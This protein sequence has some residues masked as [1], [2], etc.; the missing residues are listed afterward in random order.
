MAKVLQ[1]ALDLGNDPVL[2]KTGI[3]KRTIGAAN[4]M[5]GLGIDLREVIPFLKS[6]AITN[7]VK[8]LEENKSIFTMFEDA[9]YDEILENEMDKLVGAT[10]TN[11]KDFTEVTKKNE[12]VG[13]DRAL[14]NVGELY[15]TKDRDYV[16][17]IVERDGKLIADAGGVALSQEVSDIKKFLRFHA[18]SND[19]IKVSQVMQLDGGLPKSYDELQT[20]NKAISDMYA[21]EDSPKSMMNYKALMDRPLFKHY[22]ETVE[23][24]NEIHRTNFVTSQGYNMID[25]FIRDTGKT[26]KRNQLVNSVMNTIAQEG[27]TGVDDAKPFID[28]FHQ[29][30]QDIK[31]VLTGE[32][33]STDP[34]IIKMISLQD[35]PEKLK[36]YIE[37]AQEVDG[38]NPMLEKWVKFKQRENNALEAVG[39]E[40][41]L[42]IK[43]L[44]YAIYKTTGQGYI[45]VDKNWRTLPE[46]TKDAVLFF[47][48]S[49]LTISY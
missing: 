33:T 31:T 7:F 42:F 15:V 32:V 41:N 14:Y 28:D 9:S 17:T 16:F 8:A 27:T 3:N 21:T 13:F 6:P 22:R 12:G 2:L 43:M 45:S 11:V 34:D 46:A 25:K 24:L 29:E 37:F 26:Y 44:D 10:V 47:N 18:I 20:I 19:L 1:A 36:N 35:N 4:V 49:L 40:S 38:S 5:M 48:L 39:N 23:L 30:F